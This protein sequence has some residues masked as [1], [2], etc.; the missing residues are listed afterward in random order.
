MI[1]KER[2]ERIR[3]EMLID[4]EVLGKHKKEIVKSIDKAI[5]LYG[6]FEMKNKLAYLEEKITKHFISDIPDAL[7][8]EAACVI[9]DLIDRNCQEEGIDFHWLS[10]FEK[11]YIMSLVKMYR[12]NGR[13]KELVDYALGEKAYTAEHFQLNEDYLEDEL[14]DN[15]YFDTLDEDE[16]NL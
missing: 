16:E 5:K 8:R 7:K 10:K 11:G 14:D 6:E 12:V 9:V 2:L 15:E 3:R 4:T 1:T 13:N